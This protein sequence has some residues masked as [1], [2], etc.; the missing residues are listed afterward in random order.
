M[1]ALILIKIKEYPFVS[2]D[3]KLKLYIFYMRII[4]T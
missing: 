1:A 3:V 4:L 2:D